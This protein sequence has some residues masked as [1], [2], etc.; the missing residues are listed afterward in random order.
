MI[1]QVKGLEQ[2]LAVVGGQAIEELMLLELYW[3]LMDHLLNGGRAGL[4]LE[5]SLKPDTVLIPLYNS[6]PRL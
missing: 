1:A 6:W 3:M 5:L 2:C 4:S